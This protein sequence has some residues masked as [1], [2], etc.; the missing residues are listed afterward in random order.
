MLQTAYEKASSVL[1]ED[2]QGKLF[3]LMMEAKGK[4]ESLNGAL[5]RKHFDLQHAL[6]AWQE[7]KGKKERLDKWLQELV[8]KMEGLKAIERKGELSEL[9]T[10]LERYKS[11]QQDLHVRVNELEGMYDEARKLG[12]NIEDID[13]MKETWTNLKTVSEDAIKQLEDEILEHNNYNQ[14]MQDIEKWLLQSSFQLMA[15][16]SV[17]ILNRQQAQEQIKQHE[18]LMNEIQKYQKNI[19][20]LNGKGEQRIRRYES[21]AP[22]VRE[23]VEKQL[24]NIQDSYKSLLQTSVQIRNRLQDSLNKFLDYERTLESIERNLAEYENVLQKEFQ[25]PAGSLEMAQNQMKLAQNL[26]SKLN[27]EKGRLAVA[28]QACETAA[29]D[30]TSRSNSPQ[31]T[32]VQ[33]IPELEAEVRAKLENQLDR[34]SNH[35][36]TVRSSP[37]KLLDSAFS[38]INILYSG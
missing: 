1:P 31:D 18:V 6:N 2:R 4:W 3:E 12:A 28:V 16:N 36:K 11:H 33:V 5:Q 9:K 37:A 14:T 22:V 7:F 35:C 19:D 23:N 17:P 32:P 30:T 26:Q 34:V 29:S 38:N 8:G 13:K 27:G 10:L 21:V 15:R 25:T 20:D 24:H